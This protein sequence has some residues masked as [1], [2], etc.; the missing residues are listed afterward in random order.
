MPSFKALAFALLCALFGAAES[1]YAMSVAAAGT[2]GVAVVV[3]TT[4]PII[5]TY[6]GFSA[7][8][9]DDVYL[10]MEDEVD[11]NDVFIFNNRRAAMGSTVNLGSFPIGTELRFRLR[12]RDTGND[13]YTGPA[14]RNPDNRFHAR[15]QE[16]WQ[17]GET[18]I[19]FEDLF[20]AEADFDDINFSIRMP[21]P[22]ASAIPEPS[23]PL[24]ALIS[25]SAL[26]VGLLR[27]R[28]AST[29]F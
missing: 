16:E 18:L 29:A 2:E 11:D 27:R 14:A 22:L 12:V 26:S 21:S 28:R 3:T 19:S 13:F 7:A 8:H 25:L 23:T 17:P 1:G 10:L 20:N 5:A 9:N 6:R 15:V 24:L 4:E